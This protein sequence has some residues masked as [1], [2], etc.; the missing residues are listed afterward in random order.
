M[1]GLCEE[2]S[3]K[4]KL[5]IKCG[6]EKCCD[7]FTKDKSRKDGFYPICKDCRRPLQAAYVDAR[8]K[9]PKKHFV[10]KAC[11]SCKEV[12]LAKDFPKHK[13]TKDGHHHCCKACHNA[14]S[15]VLR[16]QRAYGFSRMQA[17][18]FAKNNVGRCE[19]CGSHGKLHVDHCHATGDV[20]GFLCMGC[21]VALGF[22]K[23]DPEVLLKAAKY[24][25]ASQK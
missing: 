8:S 19:I 12:K 4:T 18:E 23:D 13:Q 14:K 22:M 21:N 15:Q 3:V 7:D 16:Y 9:K 11:S 2:S 6:A 1:N 24:L 17:E 20:R 25:I 5:C 10:E